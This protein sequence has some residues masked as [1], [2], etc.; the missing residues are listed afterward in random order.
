M[1]IKPEMTFGDMIVLPSLKLIYDLFG[2]D[3][4]IVGFLVKLAFYLWSDMVKI[5]FSRDVFLLRSIVTSHCNMF[6][7]LK[8]VFLMSISMMNALTLFCFKKQSG[9]CWFLAG[10]I[11]KHH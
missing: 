11:R 9:Y 8:I 2:L 5:I 7:C 6:S 10:F 3:I 4:Y 1:L